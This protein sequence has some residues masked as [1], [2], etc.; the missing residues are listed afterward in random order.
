MNQAKKGKNGSLTSV[1]QQTE[2]TLG[3]ARYAFSLSLHP[4]EP[5]TFVPYT[6]S[7]T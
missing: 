3:I 6:T 4:W 1:F 7:Q 2:F 5:I